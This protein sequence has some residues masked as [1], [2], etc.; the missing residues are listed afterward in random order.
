MDYANTYVDYSSTNPLFGPNGP[1]YTDVN[2]GE[3]GDCY[4]KSAMAETALQ[5]P[6]LIENM[7]KSNGNG[8]YSVDFHL[9]GKDDYVTINTQLPTWTANSGSYQS[10][11]GSKLVF[12]NFTPGQPMWAALIEKAYVQ[13]E[14]QTATTPG[15][16]GV[17][18]NAYEDIE[19][20]GGNAITAI[21][22]QYYTGY[23]DQLSNTES[24]SYMSTLSDDILNSFNS[25][26]DIIMATM[27]GDGGN[28]VGGHMYQ[29]IGYDASTQTVTLHNPWG[30]GCYSGPMAMTFS[31]TLTQLGETAGVCFLSGYGTPAKA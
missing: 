1:Q 23:W 22:G 30:S 27:G 7:I 10:G 11:S 2:Q 19:E 12:D 6:S 29:V 28:V 15:Y 26:D 17:H 3:L 8:T 21:T 5:D 31:E 16:L 13:F 14:A 25:H 18:N 9:N 24:K 4:F 20:G